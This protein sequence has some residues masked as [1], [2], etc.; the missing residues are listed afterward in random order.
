MKY[1]IL[2]LLFVLVLSIHA[3]NSEALDSFIARLEAQ[4]VEV[5][6][7]DTIE[8]PFL[9]PIGQILRVNGQ[10]IQVFE[11]PDVEA[12]LRE[13]ASINIDGSG[14]A[15]TMA[16][17]METPHF[18]Q[19][20]NLIVLYLGSDETSLELL[21]ATLGEPFAGAGVV[22]DLAS[23]IAALEAEGAELTL[24]DS[25][26]QPFFSATGQILQVN[27]QDIQVF[28]YPDEATAA[29]EA[30][31]ISKD[32]TG[33]ATMVITW[34]DAPHF[35][36]ARKLIILYVGSDEAT[37][38][39][40]K[41]LVERPFA[42]EGAVYNFDTLNAALEAEDATITRGDTIEQAFFSPTAQILQIN[43]Q[44]IQVFE[45]PDEVSAAAEAATVSEDG[46]S[47]GTSMM[48]WMDAPHFYHAGNLIVLY[49]G[50]DEATLELL[51]DVL[52]DPF[53]GQ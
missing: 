35:Y 5:T 30:A 31:I 28:E 41:T 2:V 7:G 53:A 52:G 22:G 45:Y 10:D 8:Q 13:A 15:T 6:N 44:D 17:W 47:V 27:G 38:E 11:Y 16:M 14:T 32:G 46:F 36:I 43:G 49:I 26:E 48:M 19:L 3:Q 9:S 34:V 4:G 50:S 40:L 18:Y 51:E 29:A 21:E 12:A 39:L 1:L 25:I 42:G 23:L 37:L 33:P 20:D 24:G